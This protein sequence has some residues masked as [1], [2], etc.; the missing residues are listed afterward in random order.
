MLLAAALASL[1]LS[2]APAVDEQP[3]LRL[4]GATMGTTFDIQ[5]VAPPDIVQENMLQNQVSK[6]LASIENSM[7]TYRP[8]SELSRFNAQSGSDWFAVSA[9]LCDV[10]AAAQG[11]SALTGGA[12]DITVGPLVNLWGFGPDLSVAKPPTA[13]QVAEYLRLTGNRHLRTDCS[14]PALAKDLPQLYVD[15]SAYAKGYGVD[16]IA[17]LLGETG[18]ENYLVEIGGEIRVAGRNAKGRPW[19]IAI[20]APNRGERSVTRVIEL[21]DTGMATSGDYRNLFEY[22]GDYYAHIIDPRNG[23]PVSHSL[24]AVTV[25]SDSAALADAMATALMVLG[26]DDGLQLAER[27]NLAALFQLRT[28]DDVQQRMS[29]RFAREVASL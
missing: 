25:L 6:L 28:E 11:L 19:S 20:E 2:C 17:E 23:Y 29:S 18:V 27:Q 16:R 22:D 9:E 12:F 7:S 5:L 3:V 26:A 13:A 8:D 21:S 1:L 15:L 4:S 24:A 14:K 10:V